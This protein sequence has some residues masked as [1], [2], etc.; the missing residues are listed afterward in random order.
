MGAES[1]VIASVVATLGGLG[2]Q[3]IAR[4]RCLCKPDSNGNC[5]AASGCT[6]RPLEHDDHEL[7]ITEYEFGARKV[8]ILT[9]KE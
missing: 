7:D 5:R 9:N 8:I 4:I 6:D 2:A 3:V 1:V